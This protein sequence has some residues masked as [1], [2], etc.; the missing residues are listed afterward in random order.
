MRYDGLAAEL[1]EA[2]ATFDDNPELDAAREEEG[3]PEQQLAAGVRSLRQVRDW[4]AEERVPT[5]PGTR[6]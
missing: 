6:L 1:A 2:L 3:F 5:P 4:L